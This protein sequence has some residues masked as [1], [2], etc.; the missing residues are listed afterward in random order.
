MKRLLTAFAAILIALL[1]T[2]F[3]PDWLMALIVGLVS[4]LMLHEF[5]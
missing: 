1:V 4:A 2:L 3:A 5:L